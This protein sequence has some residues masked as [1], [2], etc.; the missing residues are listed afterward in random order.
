MAGYRRLWLALAMA[1]PMGALAASASGA[2]ATDSVGFTSPVFVDTVRAG[3]EPEVIYSAKGHDLAYT[4]HEGTTHLD[5]AGATGVTSVAGFTCNGPLQ[6]TPQPSCYENHVWIW[7]SD[8][9]GKTWTWREQGAQY[10]G[11]SDPDFAIDAAGNLYDA[12]ITFVA[13][14][15]DALYSSPDGGKTWPAGTIQCETGDR[16]WI[17]GGVANEVFYSTA[18][19]LV[20]S[21]D[22]GATCSSTALQDGGTMPDGST[23]YSGVGKGVYDPVDGSLIEPAVFNH[24]DGAFGVGISRLPKAADAFMGGGETFK[25]VEVAKGTSIYSPFGGPEVVRIDR[26]ENLYFAWDTNDRQ[27][28][29][30]G[31]CNTTVPNASGPQ[32]EDGRADKTPL[33]NHIMLEVGKHIGP[34]QWQWSAPIPMESYGPAR[35]PGKRVLW[36]WT[37]VGDPGNVSV[38]WYQLDTLMDPDCDGMNGQ[39]YPNA[40]TYI[41]EAH[42]TNAL[43]ASKRTVIV[44]NASGRAVHQ[45][46]ICDSGTTCAATG[47]DRRLGD[48]FGNEVDQNGCTI[49]AS[50]DTTTKDLAGQERITSLPIFMSQNR[51]PSLTGR[52]CAT[53][54]PLS[55]TTS[56]PGTPNTGRSVPAPWWLLGVVASLLVVAS[57]SLATRRRN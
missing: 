11:F 9:H 31:G 7:T 36:P 1:V 50:G 53:G 20:H 33:P 45:G 29:S 19:G 35:L 26:Q 10:T 34:G 43:D 49:I 8:D 18:N 16:P 6:P 24:A 37:A 22:A 12:G 28:N 5:R 27:P 40:N 39:S 55:A 41:Y 17:T 23:T 57:A 56:P 48:Y 15:G 51:G 46:G 47:Q 14:A 44:T 4:S 54:A 2:V 38:V 13:L 52:D 30:N 32:P 3:G 25:P 21:T 42:I